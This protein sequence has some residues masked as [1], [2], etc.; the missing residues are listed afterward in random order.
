[1]ESTKA[2]LKRRIDQA[3]G[4]KA[5]DLVIKDTRILNLA[6]GTIDRGD[7]AVCAG[8]IVGVGEDYRGRREIDGRGRTVVPGFIDAHVH[9]ESSMLS[10][11]RFDRCVVPR[12]TTTAICDPHEIC[13]VLGLEGL[14]YVL[15]STADMLLDLRVQLP[16][17]VPATDMETS[18]ARLSA[19]DLRPWLAHPAVIGL[20]EM[21]N[22]PG[23]L[24]GDDAV[25]DKLAAFAG[26]HI[27]GHAPLL[28]GY[29]LNAYLACGIRTC[30][31]STTAAEAMEKL[32]KGMRVLIREGSVS[33]NAAALAPLISAATWP[34]LAFRTDDRN[35]LDILE[36]G[37]IDHAIRTA[38]AAGAPAI[39]T[40][41]A[42]T[43]GAAQAFGLTDRGIVAPGYRADLVLLGDLEA[44]AVEDVICG[45]R[46]I[47]DSSTYRTTTAV[48]A[49]L[50]SVNLDP[51]GPEQFAVPASS[52]TG[53]VIGVVPGAI[54]TDHL[55]LTLPRGNG[56]R[57]ADRG[58]DVQKV[59]VFARHGINRNVGRGFVKGFGLAGGALA[60]TV[61]HD[62]HNLIVVGT[63]DGDMAAAVNRVIELQGG[64][65][66]V[67]DGQVLAEL[68]LPIAG[69]M[70]PRSHTHVADRLK[71][72]R[73]AAATI[74]CTLP[75]PFLQMAFLALPVIPHLKITD[76]GMVDVDRYEL[77]AA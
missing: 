26:A 27:D 28:G 39:P 22:F 3:L 36:D 15:D 71:A 10:P 52:A 13:N 21:M 23:L 11:A 5:A 29:A 46:V 73:R 35:P 58:Q 66:A 8:V 33:R 65:V 2:G 40:Y 47:D 34:F 48:S 14:R 68:A 45:G 17:C 24:A 42:A 37:H 51:V 69:L 53:P 63:D 59:C 1:M 20:G 72:L 31:E 76:C 4:R 55:T 74:G 60:S 41:R 32:R 6:T 77:I 9:V 18:G 50:D 49:G 61:A 44:C 57:R 38:I 62:S 16:S 67:R 30:H 19:A 7:V 75:E 54:V 70:S 56:E 64:L 12:G 25:L 43:W